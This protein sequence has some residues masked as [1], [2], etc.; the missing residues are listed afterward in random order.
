MND[1]MPTIQTLTDYG[2][3]SSLRYIKLSDFISLIEQHVEYYKKTEKENT[4]NALKVMLKNPLALA[5]DSNEFTH[6]IEALEAL[7]E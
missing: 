5:W 2:M 1:K 3:P 4:V 7:L 6:K